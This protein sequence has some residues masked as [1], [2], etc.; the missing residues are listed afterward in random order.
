MRSIAEIIYIAL[1]D[2][3]GA[4]PLEMDATL[5]LIAAETRAS[6]TECAAPLIL[7]VDGKIAGVICSFPIAEL[8]VRQQQSMLHI[9]RSLDQGSRKLFRKAMVGGSHSVAPVFDL[10]GVYIARIALAKKYRGSGNGAT[11]LRLFNDHKNNPAIALHVDR[12]NSIAIQFYKKQSFEFT[13]PSGDYKKLSM[14]K[15]V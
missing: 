9:M 13:G 1:P 5:N 11:M 14:A 10:D 4:L 6:G 7:K 8:Q 12:N 2:F 3:Y 15:K